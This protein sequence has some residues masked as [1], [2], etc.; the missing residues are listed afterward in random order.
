MMTPISAT[1][2][3]NPDDDDSTDTTLTSNMTSNL[4]PDK[5]PTFKN[6]L[7]VK[8]EFHV[9]ST[10][11]VAPHIHKTMLD[12]LETAYP[13]T[14]INTNYDAANN[15]QSSTMSE[16]EYMTSFNY[17]SFPRATHRRVCFAHNISTS[18][19]FKQIRD[20][21]HLI[22]RQHH[23]F[24]RINPWD[25][26]ELDIVNVGW[27]FQAHPKLHSRDLIHQLITDHCNTNQIT[28]IPIEIFPKTI[29]AYDNNQRIT[30]H[31][32]HFACR[33]SDSKNA[34]IM[35]KKCFS[36][37]SS[38]LPGTY[39]PNDLSVKE[40]MSV[41]AKYV[42]HHNKYL[43]DHRSI[44]VHGISPADLHE[45]FID[46]S[47]SRT[48]LFQ[49]SLSSP[50]ITWL[51][52]TKYSS[53]NGKVIISSSQDHYSRAL[54][55]IDENFL[56][57]TQRLSN[58]VPLPGFHGSSPCRVMSKP[59]P[60]DTY[61]KSLASS[62]SDLTDST[63]FYSTPNAWTKPL[64]FVSTPA[65]QSNDMSP[66]TLPSQAS[67]S[68]LNSTVTS[69]VNRLDHLQKQ[70]DTITQTHQQTIH[71]TIEQSIHQHHAKYLSM[72]D[73]LNQQFAQISTALHPLIQYHQQH[74]TKSVSSMGSPVSHPSSCDPSNN[75]STCIKKTLKT[76]TSRAKILT[77][78]L[79]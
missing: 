68:S 69:L 58:P 66:S 50:H 3:S 73:S 16:E 65:Q 4:S 7:S 43:H 19:S 75:D 56:P 26:D 61:I 78:L 12:T 63:A 49:S 24:L 30:T 29:V 8:F 41:L 28:D 53:H 14:T 38:L 36:N 62:I 51:T 23:G 2:S 64:S 15:Y 21:L 71:N 1:V 32:I 39:I 45:P 37:S 48:T 22:L 5:R 54:K 13:D 31:A 25:E 18:A 9:K 70:L 52:P 47:G 74:T 20:A 79:A 55:W 60:N 42:K 57:N 27:L 72:F 59:Y 35:L 6:V 77:A 44:L 10:E 46:S 76:T 67:L 34:K 33:N 40:G 17:Q 11:F